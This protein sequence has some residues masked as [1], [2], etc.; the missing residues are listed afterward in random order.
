MANGCVIPSAGQDTEGDTIAFSVLYSV[1]L[2][3][4]LAYL[5]NIF[6][7]RLTNCWNADF[8]CAIGFLLIVFGMR[9]AYS[10]CVGP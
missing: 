1:A 7:M 3:A 4:V 5:A 8:T 6:F 10:I 9:L 2:P